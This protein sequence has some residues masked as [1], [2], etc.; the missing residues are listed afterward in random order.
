MHLC[1]QLGAPCRPMVQIPLGYS[2]VAVIHSL[3]NVANNVLQVNQQ[4]LAAIF[5]C[6]ITTWNDV[7]ITALNPNLT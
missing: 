1:D 6:Q 7:A 3:P 5:Q 2:P 4:V